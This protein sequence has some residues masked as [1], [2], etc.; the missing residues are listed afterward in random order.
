MQ[1]DTTRLI[2]SNSFP[3]STYCEIIMCLI[4]CVLLFQMSFIS[5]EKAK[6]IQNVS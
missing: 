3:F 6:F 4:N 1:A 2:V 5:K